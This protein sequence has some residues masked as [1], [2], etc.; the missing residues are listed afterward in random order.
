MRR[1]HRLPGFGGRNAEYRQA[2]PI[3]R[4]PASTQIQW[5]FTAVTT[6]AQAAVTMTSVQRTSE[7]LGATVV[8]EATKVSM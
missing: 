1:A 6:V 3:V 4:I 8:D 7:R 5:P 2:S